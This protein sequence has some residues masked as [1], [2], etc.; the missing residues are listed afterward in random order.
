MD[1]NVKV[2]SLSTVL[3]ISGKKKKGIFAFLF[4]KHK[5]SFTKL[6][7]VHIQYQSKHIY[8][9]FIKTWLHV[10]TH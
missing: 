3:R 10:S 2:L 4:L 7:Y 6:R 1:V 5:Y 8:F 9:N